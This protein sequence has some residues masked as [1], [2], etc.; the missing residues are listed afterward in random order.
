MR[1]VLV[2]ALALSFGSAP[3]AAQEPTPGTRAQRDSLEARVRSRMGLMLKNQLGM[4]D[5][6]VRRFQATN[7]RF[8]GQRRTLFEQERRVRF[9]LRAALAAGD[10]ASPVRVSALLDRTIALQRQRLDLL[11]EEQ[12]ELA[13]FLTPVQRAR[14]F[15]LE[16]QL[17]RRMGE[18]REQGPPDGRR[19]PDAP[20]PGAPRRPP[21]G[22]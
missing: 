8:E 14:L 16:E 10:T 22:R 21:A 18:L 3:L 7:R 13:S 15:G 17:R 20:R 11:E 5:E 1:A 19:R 2:L 12:K 9:E 4:T 6:Q